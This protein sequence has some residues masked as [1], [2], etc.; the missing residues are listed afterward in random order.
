MNAA[1]PNTMEILR[2]ADVGAH[3]VRPR[4]AKRLPYEFYWMVFCILQQPHRTQCHY[5]SIWKGSSA[6]YKPRSFCIER[7][8][9]SR[10]FFQSFPALR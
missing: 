4:E 9:A 1:R 10:E 5:V 6:G 7:L 2:P 3:C 8:T